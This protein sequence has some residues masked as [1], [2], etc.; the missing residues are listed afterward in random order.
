MAPGKKSPAAVVQPRIRIL[1]GGEVALGPG[2]A[3]VALPDGTELP[4]PKAVTL[5]AGTPLIYGI[6]PQHMSLAPAGVAAEA[7][8][9]EPTGEAQE[10]RARIGAVELSVVIRDAEL[11]SPGQAMTLGI[12]ED[13]VL[14]FDK[15]SGERLRP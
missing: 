6:R 2:K 11:L 10:V 3:S 1:H 13:K 7:I 4:I 14:L 15:S 5:E 9:V 12:E 8:V